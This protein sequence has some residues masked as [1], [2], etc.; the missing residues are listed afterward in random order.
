MSMLSCSGPLNTAQSEEV[1]VLEKETLWAEDEEDRGS[2]EE[3]E[4]GGGAVAGI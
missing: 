4:G 1:P 3:M 2:R